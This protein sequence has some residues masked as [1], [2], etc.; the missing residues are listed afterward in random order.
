MINCQRLTPKKIK[1]DGI[2]VRS[3]CTTNQLI[4]TQPLERTPWTI[5]T[6]DDLASTHLFYFALAHSPMSYKWWKFCFLWKGNEDKGNEDIVSFCY[7]KDM[8]EEKFFIKARKRMSSWKSKNKGKP[9]LLIYNP[10][11]KEQKHYND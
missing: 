2:T 4:I 9:P 5:G 10:D 1:T 6:M 3:V 7:Y 8:S 11:Y